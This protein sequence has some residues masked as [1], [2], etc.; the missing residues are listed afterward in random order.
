MKM[1]SFKRLTQQAVLWTFIL[2]VLFLGTQLTAGE[3]QEI[4]KSFSGKKAIKIR[5]IS[6]DCTFEKG[7]GST[8][9][10]KLVHYYSAEYFEPVFKE[11]GS[12]LVLVEK[13]HGSNNKDW[14]TNRKSA[15]WTITVPAAVSIEAATASG[16]F[17]ITDLK[18]DISVRSASGDI[19]IDDHNGALTIKSASGDVKIWNSN[20][21]LKISTASGDI[22]LETVS[23]GMKIN[24]ASGDINAD[25][26]HFTGAGHFNAVSGEVEVTLAKTSEHDL[27]FASVSGD[28]DVDYNGKTVKGYFLFKGKK[29]DIHSDIPL[30]NLDK[31]SHHN[32]FAKKYFKKG[33]E[34]PKVTFK[35]VSGEI[36]FKKQRR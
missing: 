32:P 6:G 23:G 15:R 19:D 29:G 31:S 8:I 1:K 33:G 17:R 28:L 4:N 34:S 9:K 18:N 22:D 27:T 13:Y 30:S 21:D 16:D 3:K 26:V 5:T 25:E 11:E 14:G 35:T 10:V 12:T 24:T 20:G 7:S 36:N 2:S